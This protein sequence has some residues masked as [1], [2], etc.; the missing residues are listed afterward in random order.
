[1]IAANLTTGQRAVVATVI[2]GL[3]VPGYTGD[4]SAIVYSQS[5][6]SP[7]EFSLMRQPLAADHITPSGPPTQ[8]IGNADFGVIYRR[9][10]FVGPAPTCVGD[11]NGD[12]AV[13][14]DELLSMVNIALGSGSSP[15]AAGDA[16]ADGEIT[17]DEILMAVNAAL[18]ACPT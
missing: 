6:S 7:T 17:I 3:G 13:T 16:N 18:T 14:I 5:D 2:D 1:M 15:C 9:G 12:A 11:C 8:L 4:D 10:T